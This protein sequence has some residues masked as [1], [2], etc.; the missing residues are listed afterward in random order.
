MPKVFQRKNEISDVVKWE[1]NPRYCRDSIEIDNESG[2]SDI[3]VKV[4]ECYVKSTK[5][6]ITQSDPGV[7]GVTVVS[8]AKSE[9]STADKTLIIGGVTFTAKAAPSTASGTTE[10]ALDAT[11]AKIAEIVAAKGLTNFDVVADGANVVY[12]QA[13]AGT[14]SAPTVGSGND[15]TITAEVDSEKSIEGEAA[16]AGSESSADFIV[17]ENKTI[18]AGT[19]MTV[20][21]LVRGPALVDVKNIVNG[22]ESGILTALANMNIVAMKPSPQSV[23]QET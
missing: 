17:L 4:G 8:I 19:K 11:A 18:Y 13:V 10:Y 3:E 21:G 12:T 20:L 15:T 23:Y 9:D 5:T 14:G 16:T 7:K 2:A 1:A 6:K 22:D